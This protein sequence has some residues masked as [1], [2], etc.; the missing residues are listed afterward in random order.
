[1]ELGSWI[2]R[3]TNISALHLSR[4]ISATT[5]C[6]ERSGFGQ[7]V[8]PAPG[9]VLASRVIAS[10]DPEP[11]YF[12]HW[13]RDA[14]MAMRAVADLTSMVDDADEQ[15]A[16]HQRFAQM[17]DFSL[18]IAR[19]QLI[20]P[21]PADYRERTQPDCRRFLRTR[22]Q[23][24]SLHGD[25]LLAEPRFNPDGSIDI[26]RWSRPQ[27]DGPALRALACLAY[28]DAGGVP[29]PPLL[30][31]L[32]ADLEFTLRQAGHRSIGPWE[33]PQQYS[34]HYHVALVQ[35]GALVHGRQFA[36]ANAALWQKAERKLRNGLEQHWSTQHQVFMAI[37]PGKHSHASNEA[38]SVALIAD[39]P[40]EQLVDAAIVLAIME[41]D[42]AE[43][44]HS[45]LDPR[46][47]ATLAV[48]ERAFTAAFPVNHSRPAGLAPAL[49]RSLADRYF[50]GGA[51]YATTLAAAAFC[52]RHAVA[53][54]DSATHWRSRGD[55][56]M[57]TIQWMT[58]DDGS[59]AE[60]VDRV[61]LQPRSARHLTWSY[62]A[63]ISTARLRRQAF[64]QR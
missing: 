35:L 36:G 49:G 5:L 13:V 61:S 16:W 21:A 24:A 15:R 33:E 45:V 62:A 47:A 64:A 40:A 46:A 12:F 23:L 57:A 59:M 2:A 7:R 19:Q 22:T 6:R 51:W 34:H 1:M 53:A 55:A 42:L 44:P 3:Q 18:V 60:Q 26:L 30:S 38:Q 10:W 32:Q 8:V 58:P 31:L 54:P 50:G 41:A 39:E 9:S 17:V 48:L 20:K 63:F 52:Y 14:A 56:W 27:L 25:K 28:L 4:A 43:V 11:D 29:T 37:R